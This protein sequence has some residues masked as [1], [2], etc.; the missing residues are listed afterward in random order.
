[1]DNVIDLLRDLVQDTILFA[2]ESEM[3]YNY[4]EINERD[5]HTCISKTK[6]K[7]ETVGS[8]CRIT[9]DKCQLVLPKINLVN[10]TDNENFYYG[11]M[12]DELIRYNRIKSFYF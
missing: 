2:S 3:P 5:L 9:N 6:D 12:A 11:R 4:T 8:V 7:C 10:G 1:M